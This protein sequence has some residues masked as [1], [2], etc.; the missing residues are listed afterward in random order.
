MAMIGGNRVRELAGFGVSG[1]AQ[2]QLVYG[3]PDAAG[4]QRILLNLICDLAIK[5]RGV[6]TDFSYLAYIVDILLEV[7]RRVT[8]GHG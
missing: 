1:I 4:T 3:A 6:F 7:V 2:F 8:D 5:S